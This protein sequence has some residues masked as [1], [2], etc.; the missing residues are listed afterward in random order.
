MSMVSVDLLT[1]YVN[2]HNPLDFNPLTSANETNVT[3]ILRLD[4][5]DILGYF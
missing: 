4:F 5:S 2:C 3:K 1:G